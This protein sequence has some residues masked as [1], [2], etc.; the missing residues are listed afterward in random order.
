MAST[1]GTARGSTHGSWRPLAASVA[2][3]P[4]SVTVSCSLAMV[5][6]G[7]KATRMSS[8]SPMLMPPCT[9]PEWLVR[10]CTSPSRIS[11]GSLWALPVRV[12][13]P[14]PEPISNPFEAGSDISPLARSASSLSNTGMPQPAGTPRATASTTPPRESPWRRAQSMRSIMASAQAASGQRAMFAS[15]CS[16]VTVSG[17]TS[18][19]RCWTCLT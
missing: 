7:L 12:M 5:A 15:T 14:K 1:M 2:A 19:F 10:V 8:G 6:V 16:G 3:S 4:S 18:A 11:K 17:S 13:P 9:P